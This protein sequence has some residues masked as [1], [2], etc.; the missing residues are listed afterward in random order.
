MDIKNRKTT[1]RIFLIGHAQY[2]TIIIN[3]RLNF[4]DRPRRRAAHVTRRGASSHS[5]LPRLST[6][7]LQCHN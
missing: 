3:C 2:R 4:L 6:I 5:A 1:L 7:K